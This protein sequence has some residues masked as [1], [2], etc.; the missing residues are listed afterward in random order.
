MKIGNIGMKK[1]I[2]AEDKQQNYI[3]KQKQFIDKV[4]D[5]V[6]KSISENE[7]FWIFNS[8]VEPTYDGNFEPVRLQKNGM[9]NSLRGDWLFNRFRHFYGD[10][11]GLTHSEVEDVYNAALYHIF[12]TSSLNAM[13]NILIGDWDLEYTPS[14]ILRQEDWGGYL[15]RDYDFSKIEDYMKFI[16]DSRYGKIDF[17]RCW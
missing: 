1:W 3:N 16:N 4:K 6:I 15:D 8:M 13:N 9:L 17:F 14:L 12:K 11:Y 2:L 7:R 10:M 5:K